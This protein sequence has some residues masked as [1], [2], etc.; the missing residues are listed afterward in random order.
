M[1]AKEARQIAETNNKILNDSQYTKILELIK[2]SVNKGKFAIDVDIPKKEVISKLESDGY[3]CD[4]IQSGINE[5]CL[6]I[7]W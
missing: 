7:T 5:F 3:I 6:R 1:N 2:V 4:T